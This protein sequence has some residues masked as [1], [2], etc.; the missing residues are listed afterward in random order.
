MILCDLSLFADHDVQ[1]HVVG[2]LHSDR[3]DA[4]EIL[5]CLFDVFFD[6]AVMLGNADALACKYGGLK[7][8]GYS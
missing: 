4:A 2:M 1:D 3:S 5:N 6:D 8:T 7:G